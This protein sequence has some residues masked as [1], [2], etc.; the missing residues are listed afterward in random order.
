MVVVGWDRNPEAL[1]DLIL[2]AQ[3]GKSGKGIPLQ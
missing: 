3:S 1:A 2:S